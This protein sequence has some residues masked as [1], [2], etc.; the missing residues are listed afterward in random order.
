MVQIEN[1]PSDDNGAD[2]PLSYADLV[3][4]F[5]IVGLVA[6]GVAVAIA[7][8]ETLLLF[9]IAFLIA[10]VLNPG[11]ALLERRGLKRGLAV[12]LLIVVLF[13]IL[14]L[15]VFLVVPPFFE[16]LQQLIEQIPGEWN[17]LYEQIQGWIKTY[18]VL[19]QALPS[20]AGDML[21]TVTGQVGGIANFL[22]RST[23]NLANGILIALLCLLVVIFTLIEPEPITTA[24]LELVPP[25]YREP[26]FRSLAR[27]MHQVSAWARGVVINGV[28]TGASTAFYS[29]W[30]ESNPRSYSAFSLFWVN[31]YQSS[32][33][34][35]LP[36]PLSS[37][38]RVWVLVNS[39]SRFSRSCLCNKLKPICSSLLSWESR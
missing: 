31:S 3:R 38:R 30:S 39:F 20:R 27:M 13:A 23:L 9:A 24:Y 12:A 4:W 7:I 11:V 1:G 26:A 17:R 35:L 29:R 16:Q 37:W 22:L 10:M 32:D 6:L 28:A 21:N 33:R 5:V 18:P 8:K 15:V 25:R 14:A 34:S 19:Q 36:F 2:R